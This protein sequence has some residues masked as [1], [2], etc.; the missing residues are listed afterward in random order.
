MI[1]RYLKILRYG[2]KLSKLYLVLCFF[3]LILS[4]ASSAVSLLL[5]KI[6]LNAI[7]AEN[8][9]LILI[10]LCLSFSLSAVNAIIGRFLS[11]KLSWLREKINAQV[12][13]D[14]LHKSINLD[15][16]YFDQMGAYD[17]YTIAFGRCCAIVQGAF[18]ILL[19]FVS[20]F[21]QVGLVIYVLSWLSPVVL[22]VFLIVCIVQTYINNLIQ[23]D[24]Y[25][26]QKQMNNHNRKLNYLYRLFYIPEFMRDIRANDIKQFIFKKKQEVT[27]TVLSDTCSTNQKVSAKNCIVTMLSVV[28]S[29]A[30]MLYFSLEVVWQRIWYD[31]F[32]VSLNAYNQLKSAFSQILS[33][34]VTLSANDLYIKD[35]LS[36]METAS[37]VTC[38]TRHLTSVDLVEFRDVSFRYPNAN[39]NSLNKVNFTIRKG[40]HVAIIGKNGAGKTTIIKLLLRL[41][42]PSS[43]MIL[44]NGTDIREYDIS[45]LR[46]TV[47][48]LF[49]DYSVYAFSIREN[50]TL[51]EEISDKKIMAALDRVGL[52]GKVMS[53]PRGLDTP[54]TNQLYEGGIEFSGGE[55][56]RLAL[57]R[58]YLR[59]QAFF[60][61]DEPTS[62]LD[63]FVEGRFYEDLLSQTTNTMVVI[64]HRITFTY[65]MS[66]IICLNEGC[67]VEIGT[68]NDLL[69]NP[70]SLYKEMYDLNTSKY[71]KSVRA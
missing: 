24:N 69:K 64:S 46:K 41:Y 30:T 3:Q 25:K 42:D 29:F 65:R 31:D 44:I 21:L 22:L 58:A 40:E 50:L 5:P 45:S 19:L 60:V 6:L 67:V 63:P 47:S 13:D 51:G 23:R 55:T 48:V 17:K 70:K 66:K 53:F 68:P 2:I 28:E 8:L 57:A 9:K 61:F 56:Q 4:F 1:R 27:E 36:F 7:A 10:V 54:I 59:E 20:S 26:Y 52:L 34:F 39:K 32:V 62:N 37:N 16:E 15:L 71:I 43:G 35:Y 11:P 33:N 49:Q 18:D 12:I 38:G 14:F